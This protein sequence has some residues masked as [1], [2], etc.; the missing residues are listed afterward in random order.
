[1]G[2]SY[3]IVREVLGELAGPDLV[4]AINGLPLSGV[5]ALAEAILDAPRTESLPVRP[6]TQIWPLIALRSSVFF[7][8]L[9]HDS[10]SVDYASAGIRLSA[11][12]DLRSIGTG[13]FSDGIIRALLYCHGLAIED[14]LCFAAELHLSRHADVRKISRLALTAATASLAEIAALLDNDIVN[15]FHTG[16]EEAEDANAV[17]DAMLDAMERADAPYTIED[18]WDQFE[19]EFVTGLSSPLQRLWKQVRGGN[20]SPDLAYVQQAVDDGD[21]ALADMFIDV[22]SILNPRSIVANAVAGTAWTVALIERLGG[23]SDLLSASPLMRRML[24]L[25]YPDPEVQVRVHELARTTVPNLGAL[26]VVDLVA[27]RQQSEALGRWRD[28]LAQAL[29]YATR[30]RASGA[31]PGAVQQGVNELIADARD[32]VHRE[33][34]GSRVLSSR[35]AVSFVAGAMGGAGGS[36]IGGT[37][38]AVAGGAAAGVLASI[39]QALGNHQG[40]PRFLDRHYVAF[41]VCE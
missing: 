7:D 35:N 10:S 15:L 27:I 41:G 20:S 26:S 23:S 1:M 28:D 31:S 33:A 39:I 5:D 36:A 8:R 2:N 13:I 38:S 37:P 6:V 32:K 11:A 40:V 30:A 34:R 18:A 3:D 17:G 14:P 12:T 29:D 16:G 4:T 22:L 21:A 24:Y 19:V 25:G 9:N